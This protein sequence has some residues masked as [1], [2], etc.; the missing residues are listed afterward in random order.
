ML[1]LHSGVTMSGGLRGNPQ[2]YTDKTKEN[3]S[4]QAERSLDCDK[5]Y[6]KYLKYSPIWPAVVTEPP[7]W[8][9]LPLVLI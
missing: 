6:K 1:M 5:V 3:I 2:I 9:F 7:L 4:Q 8:I